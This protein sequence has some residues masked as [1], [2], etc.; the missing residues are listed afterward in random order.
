MVT[1]SVG[2]VGVGCAC[3][4]VG[5]FAPPPPPPPPAPVAMLVAPPPI[6]L[7]IFILS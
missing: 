2:V 6:G 4:V 1:R 5:F 3:D 7:Q